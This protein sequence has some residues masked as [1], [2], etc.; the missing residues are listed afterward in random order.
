[1]SREYINNYRFFVC[2]KFNND[3][4][5]NKMEWNKME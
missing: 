2:V 5:W 1:M 4:E 3:M